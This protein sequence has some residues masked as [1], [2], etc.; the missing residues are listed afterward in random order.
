MIQYILAL[1]QHP[2]TK[3]YSFSDLIQ[4][5]CNLFPF[6]KV[7]TVPDKRYIDQI[8]QNGFIIPFDQIY[9]FNIVIVLHQLIQIQCFLYQ[10]KD[11]N[12]CFQF[13]PKTLKSLHYIQFCGHIL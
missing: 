7:H 13:I 5:P 3:V 1:S 12:L 2:C 6:Y 9:Q 11:T 8:Y 10:F 4:P